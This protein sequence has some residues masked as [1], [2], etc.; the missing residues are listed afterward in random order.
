VTVALAFKEQVVE[1]VP[2]DAHDVPVDYV[3]TV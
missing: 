3:L 2:T 1:N